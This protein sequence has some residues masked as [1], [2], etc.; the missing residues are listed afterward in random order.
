MREVPG[1][2]YIAAVVLLTVYAQLVI[3]WQ[4]GTSG[5]GDAAATRLVGLL[6]LLAN[7]W[8]I[9]AFV[10]AGVAALCWMLALTHYELSKAYPFVGLTFVVVL[11]A[12]PLFFGEAL[13]IP[14]VAGTLL[15]VSGLAIAAQ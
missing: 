5:T 10:A 4:V 14:K 13:T 3:K 6:R 8:V 9:S 15:V 12:G 1:W 2:I 11:L 7:P